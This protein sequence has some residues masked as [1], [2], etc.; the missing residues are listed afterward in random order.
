MK[1]LNAYEQEMYQFLSAAGNF[2]HML[3]VLE[4][5]EMVKR[6]LLEEFWEGVR[7]RVESRLEIHSAGWRLHM[8]D[9][10]SEW[11]TMALTKDKWPATKQRLWDLAI[12]WGH[13]NR[14]PHFGVWLNLKAGGIDRSAV[15]EKIKQLAA[16]VNGKQ[17]VVQFRESDALDWWP[18]VVRSRLYFGEYSPNQPLLPS[19][20]VRDS[21]RAILPEVREEVMQ[22]HADMMVELALAI[23][24]ELD[25]I[26]AGN[27]G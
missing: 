23:S 16:L 19:E 26:V 10:P 5:Y 21:L 11:W 15:Y 18:L 14:D 25:W 9:Y 7:S 24:E 1:S 27:G 2:E 17:D 8:N 6:R 12:T 4:N 20:Q 3:L 13:M 22:R